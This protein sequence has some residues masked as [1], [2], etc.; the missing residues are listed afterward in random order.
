MTSLT[1]EDVDLQLQVRSLSD[2]NHPALARL[3]R[4][5]AA[6]DTLEQVITSYDRMHHRHNRS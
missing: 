1:Q 4:E 3:Q 2:A 6:G 5:L